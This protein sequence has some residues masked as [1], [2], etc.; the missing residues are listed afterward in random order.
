[1]LYKALV[2]GAV[3]DVTQSELDQMDIRTIEHNV[4]HLLKGSKGYHVKVLSADPRHKEYKLL[5]EGVEVDVVLKDVV[6][7]Q[8][9]AM[10]LDV[11]ATSHSKDIVAPMPGLVLEINV[12]KGDVTESGSSLIILEA[13]KMENVLSSPGDGTIDEIHVKPGQAVEKGQLLVTFE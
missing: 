4:L 2:E 9:H 5:I 13:M 12:Q 7:T 11:V 10:G 6:E 1:M 3:I 8:V